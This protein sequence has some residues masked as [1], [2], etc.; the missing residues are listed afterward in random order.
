[1]KQIGKL[2]RVKKKYLLDFAAR[3]DATLILHKKEIK[4]EGKK[5]QDYRGFS[6]S[7]KASKMPLSLITR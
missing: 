2:Y 7:Q 3:F 1:V 6:L 5:F 4:E